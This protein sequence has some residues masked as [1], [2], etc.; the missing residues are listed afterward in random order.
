MALTSNLIGNRC[1]IANGI[2]DVVEALGGRDFADLRAGH[3][4]V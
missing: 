4:L 3:G 1:Q 2:T